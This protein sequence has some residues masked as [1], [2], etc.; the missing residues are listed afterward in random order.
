MSL[1]LS[2]TLINKSR[3]YDALIKKNNRRY[4]VLMVGREIEP[5]QSHI[6]YFYDGLPIF[7]FGRPGTY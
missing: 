4:V 6:A 1:G 2:K 5:T 7:T 3:L